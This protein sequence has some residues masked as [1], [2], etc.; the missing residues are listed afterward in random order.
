MKNLLLIL[1]LS[2]ISNCYTQELTIVEQDF[3]KAQKL[4]EQEDKL[5]FIDFY[6]TWCEPCKKLDEWVFKDEINSQKL[7]NKFILLRYDAEKDKTFNLSKKHHVNTYPTG[8]IL[9]SDGF[10]V[11]RKYGFGG[12]DSKELSDAVFEFTNESFDLNRQNKFINGYSNRIDINKYPEFYIDFVNRDD[13]EVYTRS[14]FKEYWNKQHDIFVEE[15][16]STVVYFADQVP[17]LIA[18]SFLENK[19]IYIEYYGETDVNVA[20][21]FM[22]FG[23]FNE[24]I[25][26]NNQQKFDKAVEFMEKALSEETVSQMLPLFQMKFESSKSE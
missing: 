6:T 5:L 2:V 14:D 9:S 13:I 19:H 26:K 16:F 23:K 17:G 8:I 11:N 1:L 21:T 20:L 7:A 15:Y 3:E 25:D 22:S 12:E 24:A 18:D 10:V 4:A